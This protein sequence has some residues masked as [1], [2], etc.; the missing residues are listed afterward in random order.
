MIVTS[1]TTDSPKEIQR[2][3]E[4]I[5]L[6][7]EVVESLSNEPEATPPAAE[8]LTQQQA[9]EGEPQPAAESAP[10][11]PQAP[12][13]QEP[14]K[15]EKRSTKL[16]DR[17]DELTRERYERDGRI[18]ELKRQV[19]GL[20]AQ[21]KEEPKPEAKPAA[22]SPQPQP[23]LA[24]PAPKP[25]PE[26]KN[27]DGTDKY[28]GAWDPKFIEDLTD[29]KADQREAKLKQELDALRQDVTRTGEVQAS[30]EATAQQQQFIETGREL[31]PDWDEVGQ[32]EAAKNTNFSP[33]FFS[34]MMESEYAP[35]V[36][37]YLVLNPDEAK[38][39]FD[40]TNHAT[41]AKPAEVLR[42]NR[43]VGKELA[44]IEAAV[45]ASPAAKPPKPAEDPN[46]PDPAPAPPQPRA[47]SAPKPIKPV[48]GAAPATIATPFERPM[49]QK[50]YMAWHRRQYP[51]LYPSQ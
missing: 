50:E 37:R 49:T 51:H 38:K 19:E 27:P 6:D 3:Y 11:A 18:E 45:Q 33:A 46:P 9:E 42:A 1:S 48:S 15:P 43:I 31:H 44:R 39:L 34:A 25:S 30:A 21:P 16:Q 17:I 7:A 8:P 22:A 23:Q 29:W 28:E 5:G 47:T 2:A 20:K 26:E 12:D 24:A 14:G 4:S 13:P 32:S 35:S 10:A 36:M 40:A 41:D